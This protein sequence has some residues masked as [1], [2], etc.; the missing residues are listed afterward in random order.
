MS[1]RVKFILILVLAVMAAILVYPR[2]DILLGKVGLKDAKLRVQQGLDLQ[3]GAQL[4]F[5]ADLSKTPDA[6]R[7]KAIESLIGVIQRRANPAGT[8]EINVQRQGSNR[9]IVELPGV[10]DVADAIDRIGK[11][12]N[13]VFLET[14]ANNPMATIETGITGKDVDRADVDFDVQTN[15]PIV[16]LKLKGDAVKKFG[17]LTTKLNKE[18]GRLTTLLDQDIIFGPA[19]VSSPITDGNAQLQGSFESVEDARKVAQQITAGALPVPVSLVE[20]RSVGPTLGQE[21]ISRSVVA[22]IIGLTIVALFMIIYYRLAGVVA[23]AALIIYTLLTVAIFKLTGL[24]PYT[25]VLTL[26]GAAGFILSIG[27]AVDANILIFERMKEE[28]RNG[29][30]FLNAVET[31]FDRAWLAIRDAN[32]STLI[33]CII[34]YFTA[35]ASAPI[36]KGFAVTLGL[37]VLISMF[38]AIV[39]SR[40]FLRILIRQKWATDPVLYGLPKNLEA[41]K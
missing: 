4:V 35:G 13:L 7:Q 14:P 23:V 24:T 18:N 30:S 3:G 27:M 25:I 6:E 34:L 11:T 19:T 5:E 37:G 33:T 39:I 40:T 9:V 26:A 17:D 36:I 32:V 10:K 15:Q 22:G 16:S 28:L 31:G 1:V 12:A 20:Q 38:T 8:S 2:E 21:S 41:G 29:K